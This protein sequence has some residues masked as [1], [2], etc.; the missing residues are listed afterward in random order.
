VQYNNDFSA[1]RE[2]D[3]KMENKKEN[4]QNFIRYMRQKKIFFIGDASI[5]LYLKKDFLFSFF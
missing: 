2:I 5:F 3:L 4:K 1:K